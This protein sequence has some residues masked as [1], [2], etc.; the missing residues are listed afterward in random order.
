M[1]TSSLAFGTVLAIG[2]L[3]FVGSARAGTII[4]GGT[5]GEWGTA[6]NWTGG[7]APASADTASITGGDVQLTLTTG[8]ATISSLALAPGTGNSTSLETSIGTALTIGTGY[9]ASGA[10]SSA[11][12]TV[13]GTLTSTGLVDIGN[14][15]AGALTVSSGGV[16]NS[17]QVN[18][19]QVS[20]ST[21]NVVVNGTWTSSSSINIGVVGAGTLSVNSG[22]TVSDAK[23]YLGNT[24]GSTGS[25][26]ISGGT[27]SNSTN[28][29]VGYSGTGTLTVSNSGSVSVG[30][31]AAT[32]YIAN[33][34]GSQGTLQIGN[35]GAAG[36]VSA[37]SVSGGVGTARVVFNHTNASYT[38]GSTLVGTLSLSQIGSGV[39]TLNKADT[40]T[41]TTS[42]TSGLLLETG[43]HTGAGAYS[44][45]GGALGGAGGS[46]TTAGN[47]GITVANGG[48]LSVS[49]GGLITPGTLTLALGTGSLDISGAVQ[50]ASP[51][52]TFVL[53]SS[54]DQVKLTSG[55]LVIGSGN[56]NINDFNFIF[57]TGFAAGT[58]TLFN[59]ASSS[60]S[61]TLGSTLS[62]T[63]DSYTL[64][65]GTSAGGI[66]LSAVAAVPEPGVT[67]L[68]FSGLGLLLALGYSA[69]RRD[70]IVA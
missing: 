44:V 48:G 2:L 46:I 11:S 64:T 30:A 17:A 5:T 14:G 57:G 56:L 16:F 66:T 51:S 24:A 34:S 45:T 52:L 68:L 61:G 9:L 27:W 37:V 25:A 59:T 31:G 13:G 26:S 19:G 4:W 50:N 38:F 22:G 43:T 15:G 12:M 40:Y 54:S 67:V 20:G 23:G 62:E 41:G 47:A 33:Q 7:I 63:L 55:T 8:S 32:L 21:G 6:T 29:Y 58:Y 69:R 60:I 53:G 42:V 35:G 28:L 70:R 49:D 65:L 36:T 1:K 3:S 10:N 18:V 39:T